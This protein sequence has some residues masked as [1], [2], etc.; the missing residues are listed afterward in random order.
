MEE[1]NN[2]LCILCGLYLNDNVVVVKKRGLLKFVESSIARGDGQ[3]DRFKNRT[4]LKLHKNC[5]NSY[6]NP[7][8]IDAALK[9]KKKIWKNI[10]ELNGEFDFQNKCL[11]CEKDAS[12]LFEQQQARYPEDNRVAV[13]QVDTLDT[14]NA[15]LRACTTNDD[16]WSQLVLLRIGQ[17]NILEKN[18]RFHCDCYNIFCDASRASGLE[19][20]TQQQQQQSESIEVAMDQDLNMTESSDHS[21]KM[22]PEDPDEVNLESEHPIKQEPELED[23]Q[24]T[25]ND[26]LRTSDSSKQ[27]LVTPFTSPFKNQLG[28]EC[29]SRYTDENQLKKGITKGVIAEIESGADDDDD[30]TQMGPDTSRG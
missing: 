12:L 19:Q 13:G 25:F 26:P 29:R 14:Q 16:N 23:P 30:H 11:F 8:C 3:Q 22:E 20:D 27:E 17:Y 24:D 5:R 6:T 1:R 4:E 10:S 18:A 2:R 15:I 21:I 7:K 9:R 28:K